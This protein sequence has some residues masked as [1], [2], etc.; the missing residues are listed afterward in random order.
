M[1]TFDNN[2]FEFEEIDNDTNCS[3]LSFENMTFYKLGIKHTCSTDITI[4][5][6]KANNKPF[7]VDC[8]VVEVWSEDGQLLDLTVDKLNEIEK[9]IK[10][11][12]LK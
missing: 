10:N 2:Q 3:Y 7:K 8:E 4:H 6:L 9:A 12:I 1:T 11:E 5:L